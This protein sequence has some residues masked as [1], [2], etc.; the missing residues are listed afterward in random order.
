[1]QE[2]IVI[3]FLNYMHLHFKV[4]FCKYWPDV[5]LLSPKLVANSRVKQNKHSCV[6]RSISKAVPLQVRGAQR[7]PGS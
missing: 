5:G 2:Q 4:T 6:R 1:M 7:V 3:D